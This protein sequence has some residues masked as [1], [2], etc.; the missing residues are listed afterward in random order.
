MATNF[1]EVMYC[2]VTT[3][4]IQKNTGKVRLGRK[5]SNR[6]TN[7]CDTEPPKTRLTFDSSPF[8]EMPI[9]AS[10]R[11]NIN[12]RVSPEKVAAH[13]RDVVPSGGKRTCFVYVTSS[14]M[15]LQ[16][17]LLAVG[18][19]HFT[20]YSLPWSMSYRFRYRPRH[21]MLKFLSDWLPVSASTGKQTSW[22]NL[23]VLDLI[24]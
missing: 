13:A 10:W 14:W 15:N 7:N 3:P 22:N 6:W 24:P 18:D 17:D 8:S 11:N 20:Y 4:D 16:L 21:S 9:I 19:D 2:N 5:T 1:E 23:L 12:E